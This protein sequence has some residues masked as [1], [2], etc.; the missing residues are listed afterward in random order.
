MRQGELKISEANVEAPNSYR[1]CRNA[2]LAPL[3]GVS[4]P[5]NKA[6]VRG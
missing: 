5:M 2:Q 4:Q 3:C 1:D 6:G